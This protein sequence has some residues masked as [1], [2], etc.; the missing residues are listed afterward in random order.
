MAR[1]RY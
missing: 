1:Q